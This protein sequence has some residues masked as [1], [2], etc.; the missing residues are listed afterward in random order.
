MYAKVFTQ[1][2]DSS[3]AEDYQVRHVFEDLLK[4][5]DLNGVVDMTHAS[6]ARRLNV[7][8]EMVTRCIAQLEKADPTSRTP[9]HDGRRISRIDEHREWGWIVVN[10]KYYRNL[11]SEEQRREKTRLRVERF[12]AKKDG[13]A[14]VTQPNAV[15]AMQKQIAEAEADADAKAASEAKPKSEREHGAERPSLKEVLYRAQTIGLAPWKAEDWFHEMEGCGWL[16]HNH[17]PIERWQSI[18]ARVRTKW[19]SDGRPMSPPKPRVHPGNASNQPYTD[20]YK[21]GK[22]PLR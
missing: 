8:L 6:I 22:V 19:E 2:L 4:L 17:R 21:D 11:A 16:D 9:D 10:H 1:I 12:R 7:P 18:L 14:N 15:N 3:I 13:N 5:C 20:L